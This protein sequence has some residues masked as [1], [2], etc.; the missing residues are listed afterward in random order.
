MYGQPL[1]G[2]LYITGECASCFDSPP[3]RQYF[4]EAVSIPGANVLRTRVAYYG[5][6]D[7]QALLMVSFL[8]ASKKIKHQLTA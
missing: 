8:E 5:D 1:V 6:D 4:N 2:V 3:A 7:D